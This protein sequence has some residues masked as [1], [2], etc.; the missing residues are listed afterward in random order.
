MIECV[1]RTNSNL[2]KILIEEIHILLTKDCIASFVGGR[3]GG[4]AFGFFFPSLSL[5]LSLSS[6]HDCHLPEMV[7][8][9]APAR[10]IEDPLIFSMW[11]AEKEVGSGLS[12][13]WT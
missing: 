12:V 8:N 13:L 7:N 2:R 11:G 4:S 6:R 5:S 1:F 10:P 3:T 9:G